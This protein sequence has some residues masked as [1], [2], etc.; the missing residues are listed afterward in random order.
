MAM[1]TARSGCSS[2]HAR[3][4]DVGRRLGAER[5]HRGVAGALIVDERGDLDRLVGRE[6]H[7]LP[8]GVDRQQAD[9]G[10]DARRA[11]AHDAGDACEGADDLALLVRQRVDQLGPE[12]DVQVRG[13]PLAQDDAAVGRRAEE[14]ALDDR[15]DERQRLFVLLLGRDGDEAG[16]EVLARGREHGEPGDPLDDPDDAR[17]VGGKALEGV[18]PLHRARQGRAVEILRMLHRHVPGAQPRR[19][20]D[21][22][23]PVAILHRHHDDG[24]EDAEDDCRQRDVRAAAVAPQVAPRHRRKTAALHPTTLVIPLFQFPSSRRPRPRRGP[25]RITGAASPPPD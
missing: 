6:A 7:H 11:G 3:D 18:G 19:Q 14:L 20:P 8:Q 4:G 10:V 2:C 22:V 25:R 12:L 21:H 24:Q 1:K 17:V 23:G 15:L 5:G 9:A 13:E 16:A